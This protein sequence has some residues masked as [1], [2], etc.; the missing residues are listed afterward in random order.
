MCGEGAPRETGGEQTGVVPAAD[1]AA[2]KRRLA[3]GTALRCYEGQRSR[4]VRLVGGHQRIQLRTS[5]QKHVEFGR[6]GN[7]K[8]CF[9]EGL[10]K[11]GENGLVLHKLDVG[12][13]LH[14]YYVEPLSAVVRN[15][16][17]LRLL[18]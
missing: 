10:E 12:N 7:R 2:E 17:I 5:N 13:H 4:H 9:P 18:R 11:D 15:A 14:A 6:R 1:A 8:T 3:D 16:R